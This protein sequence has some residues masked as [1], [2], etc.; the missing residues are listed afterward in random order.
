MGDFKSIQAKIDVFVS[1]AKEDVRTDV[2][3]WYKDNIILGMEQKKKGFG[4][5]FETRKPERTN[6]MLIEKGGLV[7]SIKAI[8]Y[9]RRIQ[10]RHDATNTRGK[11]DYGKVHNTIG[12]KTKIN[13]FISYVKRPFMRDSKGLTTYIEKK[14]VNKIKII[15]T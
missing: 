15:F 13:G 12:T 9:K 8:Y 3:D 10:V 7:D 5:P 11:A 2:E 14:L 1:T 6:P 4:V